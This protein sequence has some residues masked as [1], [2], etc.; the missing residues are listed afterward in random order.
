[1]TE[2][3]REWILQQLDKR[4]DADGERG[5]SASSD[6]WTGAYQITGATGEKFSCPFSEEQLQSALNE[7]RAE[8]ELIGWHGLV[9]PATEEHLRAII[10][11]ENAADISRKTLIKRVCSVLEG[12]NNE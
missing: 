6:L 7:L 1:M 10:A 11:A 8:N 12:K 9:A 5:Q 2:T 4:T 3:P